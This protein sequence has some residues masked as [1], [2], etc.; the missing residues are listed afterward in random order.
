[1]S[2]TVTATATT[3]A[4]PVEPAS[5]LSAYERDQ[6]RRRAHAIWWEEGCPQGRD[7][8][9]WA[10]AEFEVLKGRPRM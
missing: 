9:L 10:R 7:R 6:I 4:K 8:E 1:M 5:G 2:E 3:P